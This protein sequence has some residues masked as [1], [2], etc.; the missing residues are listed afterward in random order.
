MCTHDISTAGTHSIPASAAAAIAAGTPATPSWSVSAITVTP[1]SAAER[2]TSAGS[3]SPSET[4]ECDCRS[5]TSAALWQH[6]RFL[7]SNCDN[8]ST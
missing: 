1:A 5:I 2:A 6:C 7:D 4:V 3:S 8:S